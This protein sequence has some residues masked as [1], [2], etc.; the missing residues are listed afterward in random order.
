MISENVKEY[1]YKPSPNNFV[2]FFILNF[3]GAQLFYDFFFFSP[4]ITFN[5]FVFSK[6]IVIY[7]LNFKFTTTIT[8][9]F[10]VYNST[11]LISFTSGLKICKI[12]LKEQQ[13][14]KLWNLKTYNLSFKRINS[15][16][17]YLGDFKFYLN[18]K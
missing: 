12:K 2:S 5:S 17:S 7:L 1:Y 4:L 18:K 3:L 15:K 14:W 13:R 9:M 10:K 16:Y 8:H 6:I 11:I